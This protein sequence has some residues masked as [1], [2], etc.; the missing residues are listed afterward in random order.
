VHNSY[1]KMFGIDENTFQYTAAY[2]THKSMTQ[3]IIAFM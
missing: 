1:D 2:Y 3:N